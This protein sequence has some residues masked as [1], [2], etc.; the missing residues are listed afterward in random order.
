MLGDRERGPLEEA[1]RQRL[2]LAHLLASLGRRLDQGVHLGLLQL[3]RFEE[4]LGQVQ[5]VAGFARDPGQRVRGVVFMAGVLRFLRRF[6]E[7]AEE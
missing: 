1:R 2:E 7:A 3:K 5:R 6:D 4:A